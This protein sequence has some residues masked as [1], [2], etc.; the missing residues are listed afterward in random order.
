M[1]IKE[2][3]NINDERLLDG[4]NPVVRIMSKVESIQE[5]TVVIDFSSAQFI[6]PVFNYLYW[7]TL[8]AVAK[9]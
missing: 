2:Y 7:F 9:I 5:E 8:M 4:L 1:I 6:S 3:I